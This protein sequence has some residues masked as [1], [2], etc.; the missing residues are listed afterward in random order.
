MRLIA[1]I[2]RRGC[3]KDTDVT[4][5]ARSFQINGGLSEFDVDILFD[6][7]AS[8]AIKDQAWSGFFQST[9]A[10]YVV[11]DIEPSGYLTLAQAQWLQS[12]LTNDGTVVATK[13][14]LDLLR[15][16]IERA[17]WVPC[18]L[19]SFA[20][21]QILLSVDSGRGALRAG[22]VFDAGRITRAEI[23]F[24]REVLLAYGA[25]SGLGL[26]IAEVEPV[27]D[28]NDALDGPDHEPAWTDLVARVFIDALMT[29]CG[30]I[31]P[32]RR[33]VLDGEPRILITGHDRC[34]AMAPALPT[35]VI[36]LMRGY[37]PIGREDG[38]LDRLERQR[39]EIITG[40]PVILPDADW[41]VHRLSRPE[42]LSAV[43]RGV[44]TAFEVAGPQLPRELGDIAR[45]LSRA[46]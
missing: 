32:S 43:E 14:E 34:D 37:V 42:A 30:Y 33:A 38:L 23:G 17:R 44:L 5:L 27:L 16:I 12:R 18:S 29:A 20:V 2:R 3:I 1:D 7:H 13:M 19:V 9:V 11:R 26:T 36:E 28:I 35:S 15:A 45:Q 10:D 4:A 22:Q 41:L 8:C 25:E 39:I 6:L 21:R 40:E 24:V 31:S 46:A